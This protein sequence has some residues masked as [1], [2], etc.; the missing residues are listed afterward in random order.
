MAAKNLSSGGASGVLYTDRR[1][2]YIRPNV[3]KELWTDVAP[4]TTVVANGQSEKPADPQFKMFEHRNPWV[5]QRCVVNNN[6]FTLGADDNGHACGVDGIVGLPSSTD[7]SYIGLIFEI[8]DSA[9]TTRR[10]SAIVTAVGTLELTLKNLTGT[11]IS[12]S[13]DDVLICIGN[14]KGEGTTAREAWADELEVVWN[15]AQIFTTP[16]EITGTLL[17]SALRGE[18]KELARLRN[19]KASENKFQ[20]EQAFLNGQSLALTN[21]DQSG[22]SFTDDGRTDA[23]GNKIRTTYGL[24]SAL[25][26]YGDTSGDDQSVFT[27][28]EAT[29][30]YSDFVDA[31]EKVFQYVPESGMKRAFCGL[32]AMSYW[33]KMSGTTGLAANSGWCVELSDMKRDTLGFNYKILE[34]PHG[35][36]QLIPTPA[37][38]GPRNKYMLVVSEEN[39]IHAIYRS[40][41]FQANIKTDDAYD[42]VKDQYFSDEGIGITLLESHNLFKI[43]S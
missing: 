23:S 16:V 6:A 17:E 27:I 14:A 26:D 13:D 2:F 20:R 22:E 30:K 36:L 39:L 37:L 25:D 33:S 5:N 15:E 3:V 18:T 43:T 8:W 35:I 1:D 10:G 40:P 31:M 28:S 24:I 32:G 41:K 29:Y 38:R 34:S 11:N 19:Q 21:L 7:S 12:V 42:G 4:F 9:E